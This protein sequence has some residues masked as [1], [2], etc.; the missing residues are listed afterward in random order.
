M[1]CS[2]W[3]LIPVSKWII[4]P[5]ISELTLL[6]PV[7]TRGITYLLSGMSHQVYYAMLVSEVVSYP[8]TTFPNPNPLVSIKPGPTSDPVKG[9]G[10]VRRILANAIAHP[11]ALSVDWVSGGYLHICPLKNMSSSIQ[12]EGLSHI[13]WKIKHVPNHQP[14][15][16]SLSWICWAANIQNIFPDSSNGGLPGKQKKVSKSRLWMLVDVYDWCIHSKVGETNPTK[17]SVEGGAPRVGEKKTTTTTWYLDYTGYTE[18]QYPS[19]SPPPTIGILEKTGRSRMEIWLV[20]DGN[21][22][23]WFGDWMY[24]WLVVLT[25]LKN[26]SSSMGRMTSHFWGGK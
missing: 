15:I 23:I 26:M 8:T 6:S 11:G 22:I 4:T 19:V 7:I 18:I 20:I 21:Y 5:V 12:W 16:W 9:L 17:I 1:H 3:W 14:A 25:I 24:V 2:T 13:L 10:Q